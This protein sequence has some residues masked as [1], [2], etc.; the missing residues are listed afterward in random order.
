M[1]NGADSSCKHS[2][3]GGQQWQQWIHA[4]LRHHICGLGVC[5]LF[6]GHESELLFA[7]RTFLDNRQ[8]PSLKRLFFWSLAVLRCQAMNHVNSTFGSMVQCYFKS[9]ELWVFSSEANLF[10]AISIEEAPVSFRV[11]RH[12]PQDADWKRAKLPRF[13][14][15]GVYLWD[16]AIR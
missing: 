10:K 14:I 2:G 1:V 15:G 9:S 11:I 5:C 16:I 8:L 13:F 7:A 3:S 12:L 6:R 4:R